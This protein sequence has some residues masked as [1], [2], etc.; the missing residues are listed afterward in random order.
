MIFRQEG[1]TDSAFEKQLK[2]YYRRFALLYANTA[3]HANKLKQNRHNL[4]GK[5]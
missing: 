5:Y 2:Y 1:S 3:S 4:E